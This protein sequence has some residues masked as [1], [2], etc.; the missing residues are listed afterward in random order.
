MPPFD[1]TPE[2]LYK[3]AQE[4]ESSMAVTELF[5]K[6]LQKEAPSHFSAA[7]RQRITSLVAEGRRSAEEIRRLALTPSQVPRETVAWT[8]AT[9]TVCMNWCSMANE[10]VK[11]TLRLRAEQKPKH[12]AG[13]VAPSQPAS[14][15]ATAPPPPSGPW[16]PASQ[17]LA[18]ESADAR[19]SAAEA[20]ASAAMAW[21]SAAVGHEAA[22]EAAEMR[23]AAQPAAQQAAAAAEWAQ[24]AAAWRAAFDA[25]EAAAQ[26]DPESAA[27]KEAGAAVRKARGFKRQRRGLQG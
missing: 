13:K 6:E 22:A 23:A 5:M 24:A 15:V 2:E 8:V 9:I 11:Q 14:G 25:L 27:V 12:T 21:A 16:P 4:T 19:A 1:F 10:Q 3:I 7:E 26:A 17:T 18:P 20:S